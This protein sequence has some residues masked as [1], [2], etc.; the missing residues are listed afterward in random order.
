MKKTIIAAFLIVVVIVAGALIIPGLGSMSHK[1]I[2]RE[3]SL[4][5]IIDYESEYKSYAKKNGYHLDVAAAGDTPS[6]YAQT[7]YMSDD[8]VKRAVTVGNYSGYEAIEVSYACR[9][10]KSEGLK[11]PKDSVL[12][13]MIGAYSLIGAAEITKDDIRDAIDDSDEKDGY[14]LYGD[15]VVKK[16]GDYPTTVTYSA[17]SGQDERIVLKGITKKCM[18]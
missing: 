6:G 7:Y 9:H 16:C 1:E 11:N 4:E 12:D 5:N 3:V 18:G 15:K 14:F 2:K 10:D 17:D 13:K 8:S